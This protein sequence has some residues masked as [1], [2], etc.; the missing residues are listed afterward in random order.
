MFE[1][2]I[3]TT[4]RSAMEN[5][6]VKIVIKQRINEAKNSVKFAESKENIIDLD[7]ND[8]KITEEK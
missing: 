3:K 4:I 8:Y 2:L 6:D 7:E 5:P 1:N